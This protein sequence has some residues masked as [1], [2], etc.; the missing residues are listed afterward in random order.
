TAVFGL[1]A[2]SVAVLGS[3]A[4]LR[5]QVGND[6]V[7]KWVVQKAPKFQLKVDDKSIDLDQ[8]RALRVTK[9]RGNSLWLSGDGLKGWAPA[10]SVVPLDQAFEFFS[11]YIKTHPGEA[12][13]YLM[14]ALLWIMHKDDPEKAIADCDRALALEQSN[15]RCYL[16]RANVRFLQKRN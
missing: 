13:G 12:F 4:R 7:G 15:A 1:I 3:S 5:P 11:E 2:L 9:V 16:V 6:L 8:G 10:E 14:R